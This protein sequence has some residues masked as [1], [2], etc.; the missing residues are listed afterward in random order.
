MAVRSANAEGRNEGLA[1][2]AHGEVRRRRRLAAPV[3][4]GVGAVLVRTDNAVGEALAGGTDA[5]DRPR[6]SV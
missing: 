1:P 2:G 4:A 6:P 3:G 5:P